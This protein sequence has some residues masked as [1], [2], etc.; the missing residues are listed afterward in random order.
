MVTGLAT[1]VVCFAAGNDGNG[2]D[3]S[4]PG[5]GNADTIDSPATAK[6]VISVGAIQEMRDITNQVEESDGTTNAPWQAETSTGYRIA[7]FSS[8]GNVG[9]GTEGTFGRYKPDVVAPG[10]FVVSTRSSQWDIASY[11]FQSPTNFDVQEFD[12]IIVQPDS[13]FAN[14]FPIVPNN[15]VQVTIN[16]FGNADSPNPFPELPIFV[17][18]ESSS[19]YDFFTTNNAVSIPP[20]G[21]PDDSTHLAAI[22][23]SEKFPSASPITRSAISPRSRLSVLI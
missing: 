6:N 2:D 19:G 17:G 10:T 5:G 1:S 13:G 20:D 11:F 12:N 22:E 9:V 15:A 4:D 18:L 3:T 23:S 8:R 7:G 16:I 21:V 14:S